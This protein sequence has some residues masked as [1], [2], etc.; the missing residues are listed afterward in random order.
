MRIENLSTD[1]SIQTA[2]ITGNTYPVRAE[3]RELGGKWS[4]ALQGWIVPAEK[5]HDANAIVAA[6]GPAQPRGRR[7][8]ARVHVTRFSSGAEI[9]QNTRGRC[10]DAPCCGCCS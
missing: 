3:M 6:A 8:S 1:Q 2:L 4:K 10:E 5:E 7:R 9:H